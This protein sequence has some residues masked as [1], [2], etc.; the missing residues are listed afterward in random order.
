MYLQLNYTSSNVKVDS[1]TFI[2]PSKKVIKL[3]KYISN[4]YHV[5]PL[6]KTIS[7]KTLWER[8]FARGWTN[9]MFEV[10]YVYGGY[11]GSSVV[12]YIWGVSLD[13]WS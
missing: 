11:V 1:L 5:I 7:N 12:L 13:V 3:P 6:N 4:S 8:I 2:S 10:C 9:R